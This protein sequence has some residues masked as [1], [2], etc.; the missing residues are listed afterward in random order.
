[1]NAYKKQV[2]GDFVYNVACVFGDKQHNLS[3]DK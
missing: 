3:K 1:M 2:D